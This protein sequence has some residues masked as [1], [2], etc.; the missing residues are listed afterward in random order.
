MAIGES[1]DSDAY[2]DV[3]FS[4]LKAIIDSLSDSTKGFLEAELRRLFDNENVK[5]HMKEVMPY[6]YAAGFLSF[7][8]REINQ[9][10]ISKTLK[11]VGIDANPEIT[12]LLFKANV[13]S[14][15]VYIYAYYFLLSLGK[16]GSEAEI[17]SLVNSLGLETDP[18]RIKDILAFLKSPQQH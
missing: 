8:G 6:I 15:L 18:T 1:V 10:N 5:M 2:A 12:K 14:H 16:P 3:S 17:L 7:S 13:K 4:T 11:S 9:E